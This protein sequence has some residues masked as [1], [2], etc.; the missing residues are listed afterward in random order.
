VKAAAVLAAVAL[1]GAVGGCEIIA[2]IKDRPLAVG[3]AG[4]SAEMDAATVADASPGA[5]DGPRGTG[6]VPGSGGAGPG[7][8]SGTADAALPAD[9]P[10]VGGTGG[11]TGTGGAA[12]SGPAAPD[13]GAMIDARGGAGGTVDA[14]G[15][16]GAGGVSFVCPP[17]AA[18]QPGIIDFETAGMVG[19][20]ITTLAFKTQAGVDASLFAMIM[21]LGGGSLREVNDAHGGNVALNFS[22]T[23]NGFDTRTGTLFLSIAT[24]PTGAPAGAQTGCVDVSRYAG[25]RF[26][27]KGPASVNLIAYSAKATGETGLGRFSEKRFGVDAQWHLIEVPWNELSVTV[28]GGTPFTPAAFWFVNFV[29]TGQSDISLTLDDV[30]FIEGP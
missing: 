16:G 28:A 22:V 15:A 25:L 18:N 21:S 8:V 20:S 4:G 23:G 19:A 3:G 27:A 14:A 13:A 9:V 24:P 7:G 6:G 29:V 1:A 30:A 17:V 5:S 12:G 11:M 10:G 26:W 2:G